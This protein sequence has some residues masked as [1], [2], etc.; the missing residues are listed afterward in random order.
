MDALRQLDNQI[1]RGLASFNTWK[2]TGQGLLAI[3]EYAQA[4]DALQHAVDYKEV[5]AQTRFMFAEAH[6]QLGL[7]S[8][9]V[10]IFHDIA[11]EEGNLNSWCNLATVI[12]GDP[13]A[14]PTQIKDVRTEFAERLA[15]N[16]SFRS[17]AE[18]QSRANPDIFRIGYLSSF[19]S[20]QNYMKPVSAVL[21]LHD[22]KRFEIHLISD[23]S[24]SAE[25]DGTDSVTDHV[26]DT[27]R[28]TNE[29]L[30][31]QIR[32]LELDLLIDLNGYSIPNRLEIYTQ[33]LA[34]RVAAWFNMYATSGMPGIDWIIGD[35]FVAPESEDSDYTESVYRLPQS[36]L[37]FDV[38]Y[39]TPPVATAPYENQDHLT[40]GSLVSQYKITPEV[41]DA[42]SA[43]L[44]ACTGAR[45]V[46]AN[47]A[48]A[49]A[50]NRD[51]VHQ[52]FE[53]R[54]I[55]ANRIDCLPPADHYEYLQYYDQIDVALDAFPYNGGT[56]T[57]EAIWQGVP[58]L[59]LDGDRWASRTSGTL[60]SHC[61]LDQFINS[62]IADYVASAT[63]IEQSIDSSHWLAE[64]RAGMRNQIHAS[65]VCDL[66]SMTESIET[67][68]EEI[69]RQG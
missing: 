56:T 65:S 26:H 2:L 50:C 41:Y 54:S 6:F 68:F 64:Q 52:Q 17:R 27:H 57:T 11:K 24:T 7:V 9:A 10:T 16:G 19:F 35:R 48:L 14:S 30:A 34:P 69:I 22:R 43:V 40:F 23:S 66:H 58:T 33:R 5:D 47:R 3:R 38:G 15:A 31:H 8:E 44:R 55:E 1:T 53:A 28:L 62:S 61:S 29:Q 39:E 49:S 13:H 21:R 18:P 25:I 12:P 63:K 46:L 37:S 45:L 59:T 42:W 32:G 20:H 67:A 4:I 51:F 60:L 36:Y